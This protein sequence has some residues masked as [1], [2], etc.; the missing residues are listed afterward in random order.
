MRPQLSHRS[1]IV[2]RSL[3]LL[4]RRTDQMALQVERVVPSSRPTGRTERAQA[5]QRRANLAVNA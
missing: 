2:G 4:M 1:S 5:Q 3:K